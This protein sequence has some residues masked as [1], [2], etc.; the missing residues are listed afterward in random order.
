MRRSFIGVAAVFFLLASFTVPGVAGG[1]AA[2]GSSVGLKPPGTLAPGLAG[3]AQYALNDSQLARVRGGFLL[4]NG[5]SFSFGFQQI[6]KLGQTVVQSILVPQISDP[7]IHI[8]V[9]VVGGTVTFGGQTSTGAPEGRSA[10][11]VAAGGTSAGASAGTASQ[12]AVSVSVNGSSVPSQPTTSGDAAVASSPTPNSGSAT[13]AASSGGGP[14]AGTEY[15]VPA[16]TKA[17]TVSTTV[18]GTNGQGTTSI[19]TTLGS[20]GILNGI[21]NSQSNEVITQMTQM[22][23]SLNGLAQAVAAAQAAEGVLASATRSLGMH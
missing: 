18:G 3:L 15:S 13:A 10:P 21:S 19:Q 20:N 8:P 9:Y 12:Q 7:V 16:S 11:R 17:I 14:S 4:P 1:A 5:V 23:I 6:T 2:D 22:N